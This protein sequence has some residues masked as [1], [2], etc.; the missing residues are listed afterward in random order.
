MYIDFYVKILIK[1]EMSRQILEKCSNIKF[2]ENPTSWSL[3]VPCGRTDMS[4]V[5]V[6][7]RDSA[8]AP[9]KHL[10]YIKKCNYIY[11]KV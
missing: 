4:K 5:T 8:N 11:K 2:H 1:T 3:F 9:K 7:F 6:A 10:R